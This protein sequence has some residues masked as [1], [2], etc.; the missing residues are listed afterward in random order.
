MLQCSASAAS[1]LITWQSRYFS[2][3]YN[4]YSAVFTWVLEKTLFCVLF[5]GIQVCFWKIFLSFQIN[6][7][8]PWV[9]A[10]NLNPSKDSKQALRQRT[11]NCNTM[12]HTSVEI[13]TYLSFRKSSP[14]KEKWLCPIWIDSN[15]VIVN[16]PV[17][18]A[19]HRLK[20]HT[21]AQQKKG[22]GLYIQDLNVFLAHTFIKYHKLFYLVISGYDL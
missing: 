14:L 8:N 11:H 10:R 15:I 17:R 19:L 21:H 16:T 2:S 18:D 3:A 9:W 22:R 13:Y 1:A 7:L 5:V 20:P 12:F 6:P 4:K